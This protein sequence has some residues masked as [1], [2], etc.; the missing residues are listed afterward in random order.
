VVSAIGIAR[1]GTIWV[2][3]LQGGIAAIRGGRVTVYGPNEGL[4]A[5]GGIAGLQLRDVIKPAYRR[6]SL[7]G[8]GLSTRMEDIFGYANQTIQRGAGCASAV[9]ARSDGFFF[10]REDAKQAEDADHLEGPGCKA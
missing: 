9:G 7:A 5:S 3:G 10:G 8:A 6:V 1:D 4:P 2:G